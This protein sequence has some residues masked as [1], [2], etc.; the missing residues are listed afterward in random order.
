MTPAQPQPRNLLVDSFVLAGGRSSRMGS[1]KA[2]LEIGG[3]PLI[4]LALER[5]RASG[6]TPRICGSR[7]DLARFAPALPDR[8]P[9]AGPLAGLEAALAASVSE[10][11]L[12]LP[13]D[14]PALPAAFLRWLLARAQTSQAL[15]TV[16]Y[17]AG[18][19]QPLC[20]VYSRHLLPGIRQS[21]R[22][23]QFKVLA[24][25][26]LAAASLGQ[27]IDAFQVESVASALPPGVWPAFPPPYQWFRNVNSHFD[28]E[29]LLRELASGAKPDHP[30]S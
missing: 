15:A 25:I 28:F 22:A 17:F 5:L 14:L 20:A 23:G 2:L 30:I 27:R 21:L 16:P 8:F 13:V 9:N 24:A 4:A 1:D 26:Q 29:I 18:R 12:F 10:L 19:A 6:T 7:S 3:Q 11:S